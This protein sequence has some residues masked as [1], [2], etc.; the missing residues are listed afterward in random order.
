MKKNILLCII[1]CHIL[2]NANVIAQTKIDEIYFTS[3]THSVPASNKLDKANETK[4][5][6]LGGMALHPSQTSGFAMLG[7]VKT[8]GSYIKFKTDLNFDESF[9][10]EGKSTDS[11]YFTGETQKGRYAI[12]GGLLWHVFSPV[13][14]YGG[15][16]Y[17]NRWVN[18]K[19][20]S[21][22]NF[23]VTD[24]SYKGAEL[25]TGLMIKIQKLVFSGGVSVTSFNYM[26]A[27]IGIGIM[28]GI[29]QPKIKASRI[30]TSH[31]GKR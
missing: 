1:V 23:R 13:L 15:L 28:F 19:M 14:L 24:I 20:T 22:A 12:T 17:G 4:Y 11:R 3:Q 18:W 6:L 16:G 25:E 31:G 26:E 5:L 2:C 8:V 27:N 21:G 9:S 10:S 7:V 30:Q 29:T